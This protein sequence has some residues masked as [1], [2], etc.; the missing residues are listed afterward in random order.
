[1]LISGLIKSSSF[2]IFSTSTNPSCLLLGP[3]S[4][5]PLTAARC[6]N[7]LLIIIIVMS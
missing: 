4:H 6:Y 1:M 2:L 7:C 3:A 5:M